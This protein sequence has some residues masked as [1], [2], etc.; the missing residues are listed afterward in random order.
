MNA[1]ARSLWDTMLMS[2]QSHLQGVEWSLNGILSMLRRRWEVLLASIAVCVGIALLLLLVMQPQYTASMELGI[3]TKPDQLVNLDALMDDYLSN[4]SA[5]TTELDVIT[6][7]KIAARVIDKLD[8]M[9]NPDFMSSGGVFSHIIYAV[10]FF[11]FPSHEDQKRAGEADANARRTMAVNGFL[12]HL[13]VS[14]KPRSYTIVVQY[15][16]SDPVL[17]ARI[18]NEVGQQYLD[19]QLED[20]FDATRRANDWMNTRIAE[21]QKKVEAS[22]LAVKTF[23]EAHNLTEAQGVLLSDQQLSELNSQLILARTQLAEAEAKYGQARKLQNQRGGIESAA[24]VLDNQLI[25]NLREQEAEVRS[26]LSDL[27][28]RY[29]PRHPRIITTKNQLRDLQRKINEE[30]GKIRESLGNNVAV[31]Q[32][33]VNTLQEQLEA[34]QNKNSMSSSASVQLAE[35]QRQADAEKTLYESFLSRSKE[36]AQMDFVQPNA[37]IISSAEVPMKPSKPRKTMVLALSFILGCGLGGA[38]M[39]LLEALDSGFRTTSQ[40]ESMLGVHAFGLLA[41]LPHDKDVVHYVVD[42]PTGSFTEGVRGVRTAMQFANPDNP[43]KVVL[44]TSSSPEEGKSIFALSLAQLSAHGGAK[45]LLVDGD[46]RRPS[47]ARQLGLKVKQGL[48]DLLVGNAKMKDVVV[49]VPKS[50]LH[51]LPNTANTQFAQELLNSPRMKELLDGWRKTY[52]LIVIDSPPVMAVADAMTLSSLADAVL[53][54]VRWGT[55]PRVLV[56]N[57][58]KQLR[59]CHAPLAGVVLTRVDL[60]KQQSYGYGD[61]GYYYGKYKNYYND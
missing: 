6:S 33:R 35:L 44:V 41:E 17:A 39:L 38:L 31:A 55:T 61:Y 21:M 29:G 45:V 23:R 5:I 12:S 51:V 3:K 7:R 40:I 22:E 27:E 32:A 47:L 8:L 30:I 4:D 19:S 11:L 43:A 13:D 50:N 37:R 54:I 60:E 10:K 59:M 49:P 14:I 34:L 53:F 18:A 57:A 1:A 9:H 26:N 24:E 2:A 28:S 56:S 46:M 58:I 36:I 48:P 52:D 16:A 20:Q 42:N 25:T 15:T